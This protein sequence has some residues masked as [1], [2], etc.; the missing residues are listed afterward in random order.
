MVVLKF[1][2]APSYCN[3]GG[4]GEGERRK[5]EHLVI[6]TLCGTASLNALAMYPTLIKGK[7]GEENAGTR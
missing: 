6:V 7:G 1:H 4:E 3:V 5:I 2:R